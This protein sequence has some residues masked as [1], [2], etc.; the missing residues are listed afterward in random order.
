MGTIHESCKGWILNSCTD[1]FGPWYPVGRL[2]SLLFESHI[3][4]DALPAGPR[5]GLCCMVFFYIPALVTPAWSV[6]LHDP[7][8]LDAAKALHKPSSG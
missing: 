1:N 8:K 7:L 3:S 5:Q 2:S 4:H 6:S